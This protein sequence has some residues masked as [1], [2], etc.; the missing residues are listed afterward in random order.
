MD[1]HL[2]LSAEM[3][4]LLPTAPTF[5]WLN[6]TEVVLFLPVRPHISHGLLGPQADD[7]AIIPQ[8]CHVEYVASPVGQ[9]GGKI[10][11]NRV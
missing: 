10:L 3:G 5:R 2:L 7:F 4:W 1:P 11:E 9:R 6:P 8:P